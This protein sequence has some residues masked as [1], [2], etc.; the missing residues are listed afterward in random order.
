MT[1]DFVKIQLPGESPWGEVVKRTDDGR[2]VIRIDNTVAG[3]L[4]EKEWS[5]RLASL[6]GIAA[7]DAPFM[8]KPHNHKQ[9]ELVLCELNEFE[10]WQPVTPN[11]T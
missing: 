1:K 6:F 10:M 11:P 9:D 7:A 5:E 4:T 2:A 3:D 8:A